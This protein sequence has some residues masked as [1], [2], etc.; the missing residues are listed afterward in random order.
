MKAHSRAVIRP[1]ALALRLLQSHD[2]ACVCDLCAR[3]LIVPLDRDAFVRRVVE[4]LHDKG[5]QARALV[6]GR[7]AVVYCAH[8]YGLRHA[9]HFRSPSD[10]SAWASSL[11]GRPVTPADVAYQCMGRMRNGK[12]DTA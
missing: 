4:L 7:E 1:D 8:P 3:H 11:S 6:T 2:L 9:V 10:G 12:R 5:M